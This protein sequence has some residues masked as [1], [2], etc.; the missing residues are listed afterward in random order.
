MSGKPLRMLGIEIDLSGKKAK[1]DLADWNREVRQA[2]GLA[3]D[4]V[5][6]VDDMAREMR[7]YA[8]RI[9]LTKEQLRELQETSKKNRDM[10]DFAKKYGL[11]MSEVQQKTKETKEA[12]GGLSDAMTALAAAGIGSKLMGEAGEMSKLAMKTEDLSVSLEIMLKDANLAKQTLMGFK[13][14]A[15]ISP[16]EPGPVNEAGKAMLQYGIAAK[17]VMKH[18]KMVGDVSAGTDKDFAEMSKLY[19]KAFALKK[20]D[21]EMLQQVPVLY[22][23]IGRSIGKSEKQVFDMASKGEISFD[24]LKQGFENLTS[25]GGLFFG[26]MDKR[27][28]TTSGVLSTFSGNVDTVKISIGNMINEA[29]RP[30]ANVGNSVLGWL[31]KT[32]WAM[33][34]VKGAVLALTPVA[35]IFFGSVLVNAIK[36]MG[37]LKIETLKFAASMVLAFLPVYAVIAIITALV[38]V[39][40]DLWVWMNGGES[41]LGN[42][43]NK[44]GVLG[45]TIK[46]LTAPMRLLVWVVKDI[47]NA[48]NGGPSI[49]AGV[50]GKIKGFFSTIYEF[51]KQYGKYFVMAI[52]PISAIYFYWDQIA[53]FLKSIPDR[54]VSFF[55]SIPDRIK[56][57]LSGLKDIL[58]DLLPDAVVNLLGKINVS[59]DSSPVEARAGGGDINAGDEYLVGERGPEL[60]KSDRS[61]KI[62]PNH[63]LSGGKR[64][65]SI[66]IAPVFNIS[67]ASDPE[68]IASL[69]MR[70]IEELI[71]VIEAELGL[72]VG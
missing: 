69:V 17:D 48:F 50:F 1:D 32:P 9:G 62:V 47:W 22:G 58:K 40:E 65:A 7:D 68:T 60:F 12:V 59:S 35:I 54:V 51:F 46:V 29:L 53:A 52:F 70:K 34:V 14:F 56:A 37:L 38:L 18:M 5:D 10:G 30:L 57:L 15:D 20:A 41:L 13:E 19:G 55:K 4:Y 67:G 42:W 36:T 72:E 44:G 8:K 16:F 24:I 3:D 2:L 45:N 43:I 49:I 23:A 26:T 27:S 21:N 25:A 66:T 39:F 61:G 31:I 33:N 63:A 28:M 6:G 11:S 71:P 64:S